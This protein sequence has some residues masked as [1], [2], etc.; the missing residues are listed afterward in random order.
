MIDL[1]LIARDPVVVWSLRVCTVALAILIVS[2][3]SRLVYGA[4]RGR[5]DLADLLTGPSG[6][7]SW[8]RAFGTVAAG[9]ATMVV[10]EL[11]AAGKIT[12]EILGVYLMAA[13]LIDMGKRGMAMMETI[14]RVKNGNG[15]EPA[16][17]RPP[18]AGPRG[19]V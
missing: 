3:V 11:S 2:L 7:L 10:L 16:P 13:G 5:I 15:H 17:P 14:T 8:S 9:A 1:E 12:W 18:K 6:R 19:E 4:I